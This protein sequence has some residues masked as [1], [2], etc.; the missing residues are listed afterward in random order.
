LPEEKEEI[1]LGL[2]EEEEEEVEEV[3]QE[4]QVSAA[5]IAREVGKKAKARAT[6]ASRNNKRWKRE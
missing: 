2:P 4:E 6:S 5:W 3:T 1:E